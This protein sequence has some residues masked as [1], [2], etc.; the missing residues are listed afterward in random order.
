VDR[1]KASLSFK[2][3]ATDFVQELENRE[4]FV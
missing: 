4:R 1:C 3:D 2:D